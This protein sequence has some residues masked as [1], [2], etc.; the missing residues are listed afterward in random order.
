MFG[1][2]LIP[3]TVTL[4]TKITYNS[5]EQLSSQCCGLEFCFL[6]TLLLKSLVYHELDVFPCVYFTRGNNRQT[7]K[8]NIT[9][10]AIAKETIPSL[11][12]FFLY[13]LNML[14]Q[15]IPLHPS[16][17]VCVQIT[18]HEKNANRP[19]LNHHLQILCSIYYANLSER[20]IISHMLILITVG[21]LIIQVKL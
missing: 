6:Q 18:L 4:T 13:M 5:R 8:R 10:W 3:V 19:L 20:F 14:Y 12:A 16:Y 15:I 1:F 2:Y 11:I 7:G 21:K 9:V 17:L